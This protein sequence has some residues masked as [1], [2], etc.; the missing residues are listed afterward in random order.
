MPFISITRLRVRS[1]GYLPAFFIQTLRIARQAAGTDG[2]LAIVLLKDRR[3]TFWTATS[4]SSERSMK[5]FMHAKPHGPTMR[6]L[7]NWCD[8]A[9]LVHW[10]QAGSEL[11]EWAAAHQR[12]QLEGRPS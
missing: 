12:L 7:L 8:E 5:D 4:W 6:K 1:W 2:N 3:N 9:A 10:T 11:P